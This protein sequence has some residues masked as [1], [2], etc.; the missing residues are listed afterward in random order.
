MIHQRPRYAYFGFNLFINL[1]AK[2]FDIV[3]AKYSQGE[4]FDDD[5]SETAS[6]CRSG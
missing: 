1:I 3:D 2:T 4:R 5:N 6:T